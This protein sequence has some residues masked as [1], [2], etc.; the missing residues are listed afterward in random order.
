M[1]DIFTVDGWGASLGDSVMWDNTL[2]V[3]IFDDFLLATMKYEAHGY[4]SYVV[5]TEL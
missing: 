1:T 2:F 4:T 3:R 5:C